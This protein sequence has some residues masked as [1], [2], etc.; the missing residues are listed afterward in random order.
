MEKLLKILGFGNLTAE[1]L[2]VM[3]P[4]LIIGAVL[5]LIVLILVFDRIEI[6]RWNSWV[7]RNSM[8]D[9]PLRP[10]RTLVPWHRTGSKW[11]EAHAEGS[12]FYS[13]KSFTKRAN[14]ADMDRLYDKINKTTKVRAHH[15]LFSRIISSRTG[16]KR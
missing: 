3:L 7:K 16:R 8:Y 11:Y 1:E 2:E 4:T 9:T 13:G 6:A 10:W 12:A 14:S 15:Y 5:L